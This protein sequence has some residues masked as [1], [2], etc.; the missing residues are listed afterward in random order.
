MG[1]SGF[2]GVGGV[3][4]FVREEQKGKI[5]DPENPLTVTVWRILQVYPA[6][7]QRDKH[8]PVSNLQTASGDFSD[9]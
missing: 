5:P 1:S 9:R 8:D 3:G 6:P 2:A 7:L 4:V